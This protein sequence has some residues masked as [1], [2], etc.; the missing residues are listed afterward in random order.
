[1]GP[2]AAGNRPAIAAWC[3]Y[4][5]G[6]SAFTTLVVTFIYSSYFTQAIAADELT[7]TS[8]WAQ[9]VG[10]SAVLIGILAPVLGVAA[11][12]TGRRKQFLAATTIVSVVATVALAFVAPGTPNAVWWALGAFVVANVGFEL[13]IV[14]YNAFLPIIASP[15]QVGR[16][17]GLGWGVGYIGGLACMMVALL[18]FIQPETPW[19]GIP[20]TDGFHIRATNLLVAAWFGVFALPLFFFVREP[21]AAAARFRAGD[22]FR[23]LAQ[24]LRDVRRFGEVMKFLVAHLVYNDGLVTVWAFGAIYASGTFDMELSE[25]MMF[26]IVLNVVSGA[27]AIAFGFVDDRI[28]G[29]KTIML[30]LVALI[31]ATALAVWAPTKT[32]LWVAGILIGIFGGPNQAASRSL[33]ARFVPPRHQTEFFGIFQLS[34]KVTSFMGPL[35]LGYVTVA[36]GSQRAG[37]ATVA[38]FLVAGAAVLA[39]VDERRGIEAAR[40]DVPQ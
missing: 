16:V 32:W 2:E 22:A 23:Q 29:K 1:V 9:A 10:I 8:Q 4:D 3:L 17:S 12:K 15:A 18:G 34:G 40:V 14:F 39:T 30:T 36:A 38:I 28:G 31:L 13:G 21:R 33:M 27:G 11:D 35:L 26:G 37:V 7:G 25:V 19:F 5:W 6:N 20:K 24:T